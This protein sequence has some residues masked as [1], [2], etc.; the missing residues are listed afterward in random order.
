MKIQDK[1]ERIRRQLAELY[2]QPPIPLTHADP[3]TLL[4]AVI[5]SAQCTDARVNL[6]TP[7]LFARAPT[8]RAMAGLTAPQTMPFIRTCGPAPR[9]ARALADMSRILVAQQGGEVPADMAAL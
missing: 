6:V 2:P 5:L 3:F 9:K 8:A 7:A 1:A 4:V